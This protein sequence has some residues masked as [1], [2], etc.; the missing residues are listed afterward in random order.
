MNLFIVLTISLLIATSNCISSSSSSSSTATFCSLPTICSAILQSRPHFKITQP[1][2]N[3]QFFPTDTTELC[4][5]EHFCSTNPPGSYCYV[6]SGN[7][8]QGDCSCNPIAFVQ[9]P[10]GV[11]SF[12]RRGFVCASAYN[13]RGI[14]TAACERILTSTQATFS[15]TIVTKTTTAI[16][17][18]TTS[19]SIHTPFLD[20]G[21]KSTHLIPVSI[22]HTT[23]R[24]VTTVTLNEMTTSLPYTLPPIPTIYLETSMCNNTMI[25]S[26]TTN[27]S[28][29]A[30]SLYQLL[31]DCVMVRFQ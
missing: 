18:T 10:F 1:N 13:N 26:V 29:S 3:A 23:T 11:V 16:P 4:N 21:G 30:V 14:M 31:L 12:C 5:V 6:P 7:I 15:S 20:I 2:V 9:C 17:S 28:S 8:L 27:I 22:E 19:T 24:T 25:G